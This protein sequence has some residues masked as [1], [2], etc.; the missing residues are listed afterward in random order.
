MLGQ[1]F[2]ISRRV[3]AV[4]LQAAEGVLVARY[5]QFMLDFMAVRGVSAEQ[6]LADT[7]LQADELRAHPDYLVSLPAFL[8]T[9]ENL[10]RLD[11]S[12]TL[13]LE[14]GA[15]LNIGSHGFLGYAVQASPNLAEALLLVNRYALTR[16]QVLQI[17]FLP[18]GERVTLEV[19]D[20]GLLGPWFPHVIEAMLGSF[21]VIANELF[22]D[23]GFDEVSMQFSFPEAPQHV[24]L[25]M[26]VKDRVQFGAAVTRIEFPLALLARPL[27]RSD[28]QLAALAAARCAEE[29]VRAEARADFLTRLRRLAQQHLAEANAQEQVAANLSMTPRT[30]HRRLQQEGL[31]FKQL[32][33][34]MRRQRALSL[35]RHERMAIGDI[36]QQ[37]GYRDQANFVRA[38]KRWTG[39]TPSQFRKA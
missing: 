3:M 15:T 36:A 24:L 39:S 12:P 22:P 10:H 21:H 13:S 28:V 29:L 11:T 31:S 23:F 9:L 25:R 14:L 2:V 19:T 6:L 37:L 30:L 34:D 8:R 7:G 38:F 26:L 35:L 16:T 20:Q 1:V 27:P 33:D 17:R 4:A 5:L 18:A 32:L